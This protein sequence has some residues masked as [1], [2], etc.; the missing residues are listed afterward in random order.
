MGGILRAYVKPAHFDA[1]SFTLQPV[2]ERSIGVKFIWGEVMYLDQ[3]LK[4]ATVKPMFAN[5]CDLIYFDYCVICSG[6]NFGPFKPQGE[7]L[8]FPTVHEIGRS[9]SDWKHIDERFIEGRRR[10]ILE[11]YANLA[12]LEKKKAQCLVV[13]AGFIG[14]E[15]VTEI[16]YFFPGIVTTIIDM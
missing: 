13:G 3:A 5:S 15:W 7:S 10:H 6:C 4:C 14:V 1:L 8:W 12:Q 16:E 2:I 9:V 11:E